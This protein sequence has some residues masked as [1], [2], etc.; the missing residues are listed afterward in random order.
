[1]SDVSVRVRISDF[2]GERRYAICVERAD[3]TAWVVDIETARKLLHD[4]SEAI[5]AVERLEPFEMAGESSR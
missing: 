4:L 5:D 3:T 1:M 2:I